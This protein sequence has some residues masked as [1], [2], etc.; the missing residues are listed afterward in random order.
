[1][2]TPKTFT[3]TLIFAVFA[4]LTWSCSEQNFSGDSPRV[5]ATK[6][7]TNDDTPPVTTDDTPTNND[8]TLSTDNGE[9]IGTAVERVGLGFEDWTDWDY[10]DIYL[11]FEGHFNVNNRDIVS[12]RDQTVTVAWG[13]ISA[14]S[15]DV[16][17]TITAP[18]GTV[19]FTQGYQ[20]QKRTKT[21]TPMSLPF[22][23]GSKL[24]VAITN[25]SLTHED[26]QRAKVNL[27][28]CNNTGN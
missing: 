8:P 6:K 2:S 27:N 9:I 17:I 3:S 5:A 20:G 28:W 13:N 10:N 21:L 11:C 25:P 7:P 16:T 14:K 24:N 26:A 1:M 15:H 12:N 22:K 18:N 23:R 19:S 4:T